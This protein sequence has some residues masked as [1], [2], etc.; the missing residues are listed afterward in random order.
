MNTDNSAV[1]TVSDGVVTTVSVGTAKITVT[2]EYDKQTFSSTSSLRSKK[3]Q[4]R[5]YLIKTAWFVG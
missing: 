3:R 4:K 1:A 5:S 2:V